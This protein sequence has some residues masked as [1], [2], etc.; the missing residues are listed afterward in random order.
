M[1]NIRASTRPRVEVNSASLLLRSRMRGNSAIHLSYYSPTHHITTSQ[2]VEIAL[3]VMII[4]ESNEL[5]VLFSC[6]TCVALQYI[7]C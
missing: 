4:T 7:G 2:V 3:P 6:Y 5:F 1:E